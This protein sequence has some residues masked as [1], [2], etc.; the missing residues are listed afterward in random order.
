MYEKGDFIQQ[1]KYV[2]MTT[3][4]RPFYFPHLLV[5]HSVQAGYQQYSAFTEE[6]GTTIAFPI[7]TEHVKTLVNEA[8]DIHSRHRMER[9]LFPASRAIEFEVALVDDKTAE[10]L[11]PCSLDAPCDCRRFN[12]MVSTNV[13]RANVQ[14]LLDH[15][16]EH[17]ARI[18]RNGT[19]MDM[20]M[21][22][23]IELP[24]R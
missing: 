14:L 1:L 17:D 2:D 19:G 16:K 21:E 24:L 3:A 12:G 18:A 11:E 13:S 9:T 22:R 5:S 8:P 20:E 15:L 10:W 23:R 4:F 6:D 7:W